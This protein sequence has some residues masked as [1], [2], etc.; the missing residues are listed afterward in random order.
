M[1]FLGY[2]G[3][4]MIRLSPKDSSVLARAAQYSHLPGNERE[5][6]VRAASSPKARKIG[7]IILGAD[8]SEFDEDVQAV[9]KV[10][11]EWAK[12]NRRFG[13]RAVASRRSAKFA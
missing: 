2:Y 1:L 8:P 12:R 4:G 5:A 9:A 11:L 13:T 10:Y 7:A 3:G 6:L